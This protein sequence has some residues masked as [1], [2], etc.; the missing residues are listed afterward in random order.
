MLEIGCADGTMTELLVKHAKKL[1][2]VEPCEKYCDMVKKLA[3]IGNVYNCFLHE[4]ASPQQYDIILCA[5]LIHHIENVV[6][7]MNLLKSFMLTSGVI[8]ATVPNIKSLH[9]R[10][11]V[12]MGLLKTESGDSDRNIRFA[13]PGRYD[14]YKFKK[15]FEDNDFKII[16][17]YGYMIK[18]FSSEIMETLDLNDNQIKGLFEIGKEFQEISSQIYLKASL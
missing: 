7:F 3:G 5:G 11:G 4:I 8:L 10:I 14:L 13:Q 6:S 1:D 9:R 2:V 12:K 15:L 17:T 18:P 16:E